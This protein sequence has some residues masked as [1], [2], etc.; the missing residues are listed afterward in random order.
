[1][2]TVNRLLVVSIMAVAAITG[3]KKSADSKASREV[4]LAIWGNYLST[5]QAQAF[6][7]KTGIKL[8]ISNYTSNEELLAKVQGGAG[9]IDVA[10]PSDYMV[11]IM[12][13]E[14]LLADLDKSKIPNA[15][16]VSPELLKQSFDPE[17]KYSLPYSWATAGIAVNRELF[18][19]TIKSWK[20]VFTNPELAGRMSLL[21]DVREVAAAAL[22]YNGYSVNTLDPK[23]LKKAEETLLKLKPKVK[24]FRSDTVDSLVKK[25]VAVAHSFSTDALQAAAET[26]GKIEYIL[27]EEGGTR[28]IDTVVILKGA[29]NSN[30]A[31][32]LINYLLS[33]DV[34]IEFVKTMWGGPVLKTT[35]NL[36]PENVKK[37]TAL[38]PPASKM[39]KFENLQ[40]IGETTRLYD[41]LWTKVKTE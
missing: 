40:D 27:P 1:M 12:A 24:M 15:S 11:S 26:N 13:K 22:K 34:N 19:G 33:S 23:E 38:F 32:E 17:N 7:A 21:D 28:S 10:V 5:E 41:E 16:Q 6:S 37:N 35:Q 9:G 4:N 18:K 29:K 31:H 39:A 2:S 30:E 8:N 36:L 25:E 20:D 14:G 3:C